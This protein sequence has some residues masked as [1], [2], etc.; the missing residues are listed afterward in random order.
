[1][2]SGPV[3]LAG[4]GVGWV[5]ITFVHS[6]TARARPLGRLVGEHGQEQGAEE[7]EG[8]ECGCEA[9]GISRA[10]S[11]LTRSPRAVRPM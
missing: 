7:R 1:M 11:T 4:R 9:H 3:E 10:R 2:T 6:R 5:Q 8:Q